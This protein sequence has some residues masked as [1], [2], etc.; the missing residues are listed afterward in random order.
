M[1]FWVEPPPRHNHFSAL[2]EDNLCVYGGVL[3]GEVEDP[4]LLHIFDIR[5]EQWQTVKT[6]GQHFLLA[7]PE[8]IR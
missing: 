5:R 2:V 6:T 7:R 1:S 3:A 4:Q 8:C